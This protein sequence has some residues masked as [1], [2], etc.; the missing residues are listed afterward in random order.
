MDCRIKGHTQLLEALKNHSVLG[1]LICGVIPAN[2]AVSYA[3]NNHQSIFNYDP[4]SPASRA[5]A[6]LVGTL[7]RRM[8]QSQVR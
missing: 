5:Y 2:E 4:K 1:K 3:H 7:V 8:L 6:E